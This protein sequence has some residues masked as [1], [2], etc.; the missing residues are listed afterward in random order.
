MS[1]AKFTKG[2]WRAHIRGVKG[3][4]F[5]E[6]VVTVPNGGF[7]ITNIPDATAN[8]HLIAAAPEMYNELLFLSGQLTSTDFR[9]L[10]AR[11]SVSGGIIELLAKARG[12]HSGN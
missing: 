4:D 8:A 12:E 10:S 2:E 3:E 11:A 5:H 6:V 9:S 7:E 1:E